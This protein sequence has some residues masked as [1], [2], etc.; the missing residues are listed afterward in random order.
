MVEKAKSEKSKSSSKMDDGEAGGEIDSRQID[1]EDGVNDAC[2][3]SAVV[4]R[5]LPPHLFWLPSSLMHCV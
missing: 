4:T 2:L 1:D 5:S 3:R